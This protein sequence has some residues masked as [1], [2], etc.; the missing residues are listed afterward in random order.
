[1]RA[2]FFAVTGVTLSRFFK[3]N[4]ALG[5]AIPQKTI[6]DHIDKRDYKVLNYKAF[7]KMEK[8]KDLWQALREANNLISA[9]SL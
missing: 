1:M 2:L 4:A 5:Y 6:L 9:D 8:A 7:P 3:E